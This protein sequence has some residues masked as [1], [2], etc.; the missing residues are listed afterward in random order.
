MNPSKEKKDMRSAY[1][2]RDC[3]CETC[4]DKYDWEKDLMVIE[5]EILTTHNHNER[6]SE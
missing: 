6:G 4:A 3:D 5:V 2:V 1:F